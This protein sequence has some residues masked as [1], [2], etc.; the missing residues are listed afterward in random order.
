[1]CDNVMQS[2]RTCAESLK[3]HSTAA[4]LGNVELYYMNVP[5]TAWYSNRL[6]TVKT[7]FVSN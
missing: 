2:V 4:E 7:V 5:A 1:M 3:S 6:S